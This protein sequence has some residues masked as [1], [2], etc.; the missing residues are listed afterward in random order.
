[1]SAQFQ[2]D[3][4]RIAASAADIA[5]ISGE[6]ETQVQAMLSRLDALQDAWRGTAAMRFAQVSAEW[7]ATQQQVRSN[8]DSIGQVLGQAGTTY[9][10]TEL[11]ATRMF[12]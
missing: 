9:A 12:G 5:A 6:I 11:A 3:T 2:V 7:R 1:M 10:E 8:L 4:D